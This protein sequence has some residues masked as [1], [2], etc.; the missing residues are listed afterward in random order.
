MSVLLPGCPLPD[1]ATPR[2]LSVRNELRSASGGSLQRLARKGS[3]YAFDFV[4]P[5][6][7]YADSLA[8]M[9]LRSE[10]GLVVM[11]VPQHDLDLGAPGLD[12]RVNGAGQIGSSLSVD[13]V[14][15]N[16]VMR[17]G[18]FLTHLIPTRPRRIY[19]CR[20]TVTADALGRL[21]IPLETMLGWPPADNDQIQ[22][23]D[24]TIEGFPVLDPGAWSTDFGREVGLSFSIEEPG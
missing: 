6:M 22:I 3:K 10:V 16:Y 11:A 19:C 15:P 1:T 20:E 7:G 17:Q 14:Q 23:A 18:Q 9:G 5:R 13:G 2:I 21:T 4:L 24:P 8:W 12:V